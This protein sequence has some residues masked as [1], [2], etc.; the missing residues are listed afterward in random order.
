MLSRLRISI[1][2]R[3]STS[4]LG[5]KLDRD[6]TVIVSNAVAGD[7]ALSELWAMLKVRF[8]KEML[9]DAYSQTN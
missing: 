3:G 8:Q 6:A 1:S 2:L 7:Q 5:K 4:T 9:S